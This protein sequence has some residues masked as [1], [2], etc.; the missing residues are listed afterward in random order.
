MGQFISSLWSFG[1]ACCLLLL[2]GMSPIQA[3]TNATCP[4]NL[5]PVVALRAIGSNASG[6]PVL[7]VA[8]YPFELASFAAL[9]DN[10]P[11]RFSRHLLAGAFSIPTLMPATASV[12]PVLYVQLQKGGNFGRN[13]FILSE[14]SETAPLPFQPFIVLDLLPDRL[15]QTL[16]HEQGHLLQRL[17]LGGLPADEGWLPLPHSLFAVSNRQTALSEGYAIHFETLYAHFTDDERRRRYY[18]NTAP[19][20]DLSM[21]EFGLSPIRDLLTFSQKWQRYQAVRDGLA[22][23]QGIDTS[24]GYLPQQFGPERDV[25][26]LKSPGQMASSEGV[27]ASFLFWWAT[28]RAEQLGALPGRGLSQPGLLEA[29]LALFAALRDT[30]RE[31]GSKATLLDLVKL[32]IRREPEQAKKTTSIF[33]GITHGIT[34]NAGVGVLWHELYQASLVLDGTKAGPGLQQYVA[35]TAS[36]AATIASHPELIGKCLGS[37]IPVRVKAI[38]LHLPGIV[39]EPFPLEFDLN[40]AGNAEWQQLASASGLPLSTILDAV[41]QGP[42]ASLAE[43]KSRFGEAAGKLVLEPAE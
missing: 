1:Q 40:A 25:S 39:P 43:F 37:P 5:V 2:V 24:D 29:E 17:A 42:A 36:L 11:A 13:G 32:L 12:R 30:H 9:I 7:A 21:E 31:F 14:G 3:Q 35:M 4:F 8:T 15:S 16:I 38:Q 19:R 41:K 28:K 33:L 18:N 10:E 20:F 34:E 6:L 23:Y 27:A 26:R 22:A